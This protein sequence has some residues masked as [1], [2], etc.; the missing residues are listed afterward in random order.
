MLPVSPPDHATHVGWM[1]RT[2]HLAGEVRRAHPSSTSEMKDIGPASALG[3]AWNDFG[4]L[5]VMVP[6]EGRQIPPSATHPGPIP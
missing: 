1:P 5:W 2:A 6:L 4:R 3:L